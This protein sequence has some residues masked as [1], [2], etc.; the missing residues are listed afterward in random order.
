MSSKHLLVPWRSSRISH[1]SWVQI[2]ETLITICHYWSQLRRSPIWSIAVTKTH[3]QK[4]KQ[5]KKQKAFHFNSWRLG[6]TL[7]KLHWLNLSECH[8][9]I[10]ERL[11]IH[12]KGETTALTTFKDQNSLKGG[13]MSSIHLW[14]Q[15]MF[16]KLF[17]SLVFGI[18]QMKSFHTKYDIK[19]AIFM[20]WVLFV[21]TKENSPKEGVLGGLRKTKIRGRMR[22]FYTV[23]RFCLWLKQSKKMQKN[24][25]QC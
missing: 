7:K 22:A 2:R 14:Q 13:N 25:D 1:L 8:C 12:Q 17:F 23:N 3:T 15:N 16:E 11:E 5:R 24:T 9:F 18:I 20:C 19:A 6:A 21:K 10:S 4:K